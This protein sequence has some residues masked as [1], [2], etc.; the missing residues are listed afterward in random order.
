M[1]PYYTDPYTVDFEAN[2][3]EISRKD[4][5]V[6]AVLDKSYFYPT[7]GG[8]E[9]DTGSINGVDVVDVVEEDG[10]VF[11]VLSGEIRAGNVTCKINW[12]RR[13]ENMQQHTGQHILSAAFENL[14]G[15]QTVS[16]RLG[17]N[18]GTIDL[19]RQ[20]SEN[21]LQAALSQANAIIREYREVIVHFADSTTVSAFK[22][23]KPP[24]VEGTIRIVEVKDFDFSPCG[25]TH[26]TH[27]SE[28]GVI[29]TGHT[30]KVK[31]SITRM[32]FVCGERAIK[33]YYALF[34]SATESARLLSSVAEDLPQA[35]ER[36]KRQIQENGNKLK[37]FT[38]R[39]LA[40]VC[41]RLMLQIGN[42]TESFGVFDLTN[43]V[44]SADELRYVASFLAKQTGKP[45][46]VFINDG[47]LCQMNLNLAIDTSDS[48]MNQLRTNFGVKGGGRSGFFT[49]NFDRNHLPSIIE[50]LRR[51][52]GNG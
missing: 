48:V 51:K 44:V 21:E 29:L 6:F 24:K 1:K 5:K 42:S 32:E 43:E 16:C 28:V 20:P 8:Q 23:R 26:C 40:G 47:D 38:E 45:F 2:I 41:K 4:G 46:A 9:H 31:A 11:H 36:M 14:F 22:L 35:I 25:G 33:H 10:K 34:R 17:E 52:A 12:K 39:I 30:E 18:I 15:I 19:S 50:E 27:T 7:S 37:E 13:F 49:L 3:L